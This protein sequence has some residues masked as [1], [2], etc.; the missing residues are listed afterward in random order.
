MHFTYS[1]LI[2]EHFTT[3]KATARLTS[4]VEVLS[5]VPARQREGQRNGAEQLDDVSDVI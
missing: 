1:Q 5:G 4:S 3:F 2:T